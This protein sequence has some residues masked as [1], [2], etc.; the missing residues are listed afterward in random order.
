[1]CGVQIGPT[2]WAVFA[3]KGLEQLVIHRNSRAIVGGKSL[4]LRGEE[5]AEGVGLAAHHIDPFR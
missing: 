1:V 5:R 2:F 4:A 3:P